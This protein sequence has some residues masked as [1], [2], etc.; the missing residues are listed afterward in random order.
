MNGHSVFRHF[1]L[2]AAIMTYNN[3]ERTLN[4]TKI[5]ISI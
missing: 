2:N 5:G 3:L 1:L 4:V